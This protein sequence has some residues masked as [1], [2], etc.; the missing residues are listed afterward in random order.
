[1]QTP[2][3]NTSADIVA[4]L[5]WGLIGDYKSWSV[6]V[7]PIVKEADDAVDIAFLARPK[8]DLRENIPEEKDATVSFSIR[9]NPY[10]STTDTNLSELVAL[11]DDILRKVEVQAYGF[12]AY[13]IAIKTLD[14]YSR[15]LFHDGDNAALRQD[16]LR[17]HDEIVT[18]G[19]FDDFESVRR[20]L[21]LMHEWRTENVDF[22]ES[23]ITDF[24]LYANGSAYQ[25]LSLGHYP[26]YFIQ[27]TVLIN[28]IFTDE[29][30]KYVD[31]SRDTPSEEGV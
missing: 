11:V 20:D 6:Q 28:F 16:M 10:T 5:V 2:M 27:N 23:K 4:G 21:G 18:R 26:K 1:M 31:A 3:V 22:G 14:R 7:G 13:Q 25:K 19:G 9:L 12:D 24:I 15:A 29:F 17:F 8:E 30:K